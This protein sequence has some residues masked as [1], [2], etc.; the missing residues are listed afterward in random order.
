MYWLNNTCIYSVLLRKI[1]FGRVQFVLKKRSHLIASNCLNMLKCTSL[2]IINLSQGKE[3]QLD[4][5]TLL[6]PTMTDIYSLITIF[7]S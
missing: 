6:S 4:V 5:F 3:L 7:A 1:L 2:L